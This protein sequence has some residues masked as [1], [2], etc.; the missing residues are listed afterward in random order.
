MEINMLRLPTPNTEKFE[1]RENKILYSRSQGN[2]GNMIFS[3]TP[4]GELIAELTFKND[5]RI[6]NSHE[7]KITGISPKKL[8]MLQ[9]EKDQQKIVKALTTCHFRMQGFDL[10]CLP[11]GL[12]GWL[13]DVHEGM[14]LHLDDSKIVSNFV[15]GTM[16][17]VQ[18]LE[19]A[20][21]EDISRHCNEVDTLKDPLDMLGD[22][23]E[24][25]GWHFNVNLYPD[26]PS[27]RFSYAG[28]DIHDTR[29][30]NAR[31]RLVFAIE[32]YGKVVTAEPLGQGLHALQDIFAHADKFVTRYPKRKDTGDGY[33]FK[34][35]HANMRGWYADDTGHINNG[36]SV[37]EPERPGTLMEESI[38]AVT[39]RPDPV[40]RVVA[41]GTF[42]QRYSDTKTA[43]YLYLIAFYAATDSKKNIR[44]LLE[45]TSLARF[46]ES[47]GKY[48]LGDRL[49]NSN[50]HMLVGFLTMLV[51]I[52]EPYKA[53]Q[54]GVNQ[55]LAVLITALD[56]ARHT[57]NPNGCDLFLLSKYQGGSKDLV[58][59]RSAYIVT[60][61]AIFYFNKDVRASAT[62]P[63]VISGLDDSK[64]M[65]IREI[66]HVTPD[67]Y[68]KPQNELSAEQILRVVLLSGYLPSD[69]NVVDP[70][71]ETAVWNAVKYRWHRPLCGS[72]L[73]LWSIPGAST[74][75][76]RNESKKLHIS[77][78]THRGP[79]LDGSHFAWCR[80]FTIEL[81]GRMI[82]KVEI[83]IVHPE[84]GDTSV[85]WMKNGKWLGPWG[86]PPYF[87]WSIALPSG[88][89]L[90]AEFASWQEC[91]DVLKSTICGDSIPELVFKPGMQLISD[92]AEY[93]TETI[94]SGTSSPLS[95]IEDWYI[96]DQIDFLLRHYLRDSRDIEI[97]RS[98]RLDLYEG[99]TLENNLYEHLLL[100]VHNLH[101]HAI[102]IPI[103]LHG[104]HW[105]G[106]YI[107]FPTEDL[108]R[109]EITYVDPYGI[110][111][112]D[113]LIKVL[114]KLYNH[115][116]IKYSS[117]EYQ[118]D[119]HNCGPWTVI[120]LEY[121]V[122]GFGDLNQLPPAGFNIE[123]RRQED[124]EILEHA[125]LFPEKFEPKL[126]DQKFGLSKKS[127]PTVFQLSGGGYQA[128]AMWGSE[129]TDARADA[130]QDYREH[131]EN[132]YAEDNPSR[133]FP[134]G[135]WRNFLWDSSVSE[136]WGR[137]RMR[138]NATKEDEQWMTEK[139]S[140]YVARKKREAYSRSGITSDSS[141]FKRQA[142]A[143][144]LKILGASYGLSNVTVKI[145]DLCKNNELHINIDNVT[146]TEDGW[147]KVRKS[148]SIVYQYGDFEP[149]TIIA[150]EGNKIDIAMS[151][152]EGHD[153]KLG[154]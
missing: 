145:R 14:K 43:T 89:S 64:Q 149:Q 60:P 3:V 94:T 141:F 88:G 18:N 40:T 150:A 143:P 72:P 105:V 122:K 48:V 17:W 65:Q 100:R 67:G 125:G 53:K 118:N 13:K 124:L 8:K 50:I 58:F 129:L 126:N 79:A 139:D 11:N 111:P 81:N 132:G 1:L 108:T 138:Y 119:A 54:E 133:P 74:V 34:Y 99:A 23:T 19:G 78:S 102:A 154:K 142:E 131:R 91:L 110:E 117:V 83:P 12:G 152:A 38:F 101:G 44:T 144:K 52:L 57:P 56:F 114:T 47:S 7:I 9:D 115:M 123:Q 45:K 85:Q 68:D 87:K 63:G 76:P 15:E 41:D 20:D 106:L 148:L 77:F 84:S 147:P 136:P 10:I 80:S 36:A 25:Q 33:K 96:D 21:A 70:S 107:R 104:N 62:N 98:I 134:G 137:G 120:F 39:S 86:M 16:I 49:S 82:G 31:E 121:L 69:I 51:E 61:T 59:T 113:I 32:H 55:L 135:D 112:S 95:T 37:F 29:I 42:N 27:D 46:S 90:S 35:S 140:N 146:L 97:F 24:F 4:T 71:G 75:T 127:Y 93:K 116:T 130:L 2:F 109:P 28:G 5:I 153:Y 22:N 103:N 26:G 30:V 6:F 73:S 128:S 151:S 92:S 66:L